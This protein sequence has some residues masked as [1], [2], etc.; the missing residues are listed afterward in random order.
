MCFSLKPGC[1]RK[2]SAR[3]SRVMK[4]IAP[5][6]RHGSWVS[7]RSFLHALVILSVF[8]AVP[9][10]RAERYSKC[11]PRTISPIFR[12]ARCCCPH[13]QSGLDAV[14]LQGIRRCHRKRRAIVARRSHR[15][16]SRSACG[17]ECARGAG[18]VRKR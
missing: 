17:N 9:V 18:G 3:K 11:C 5:I 16:G 15:K 7:R 4:N 8:P 12:P 14:I 13:H 6:R 1:C 2:P 10:W